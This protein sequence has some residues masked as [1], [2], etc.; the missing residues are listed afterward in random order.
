MGV[1]VGG[2]AAIGARFDIA[3][4]GEDQPLRR[5]RDLGDCGLE[6]LA[7][8]RGRGPEAADLA[9]VLPSGGLDLARRRGVVLVAEGADASTHATSVPQDGGTFAEA[10]CNVRLIHA[11][12]P[13][14]I[15]ARLGSQPEGSARLDPITFALQLGFF[16]LFGVSVWQFIQHRG[17]LELS[18]MAIFGSIVAL[19]ALSLLNALL[20][21]LTPVARPVLIAILFAQPVLVLRLIAQIHP[22]RPLLFRIAF[23]GAIAAWAAVV[24]LPVAFPAARSLGIVIAV[25]YFCAVEI[26]AAAR[27]AVDSRRRYGVARL[28]LASASVATALFGVSILLAGLTNV[29]RAPGASSTDSTTVTRLLVLIA[30]IGYLG[31]FVPPGWFRRVIN[32]SASFHLV[33]TL[34]SP[35]TEMSPGALWTDLATTAREILGASRV[36]ILPASPGAP[37]A[38]VGDR[39]GDRVEAINALTT[40]DAATGTA[41]ALP[42]IST[43][44]LAVRPGREASERLVAEI[45]GRPL[46]VSDD[47]ALIADLASLTAQAI[48]REG[49]LIGLGEARREAEES[50]SIRS[51]EARFRALLEA[52]PN[53][54]LALDE[55]SNVTWATRQ[56]G[57][58]FGCDDH[59]LVGMALGDLVALHKDETATTGGEHPVF[60]SETTGRR[61]D[62]THFPAE[63]ARST[64]ELDGRPF[65]V[66]V[67]SDVTWRHEADQI[68]DRFVGVLSHELRTPV[69]SIYGGTQVLL[70]RGARLD[71][72][73]RNELLVNVA[74]EA[75][76]LQRMIENLVAMARIERGGDF[77]STRPVL[78]DRIIPQLVERERALWPEVTIEYVPSGPIQMVA[79][80][81]EYLAQIMRNLLSNAAKYSG[82]GSTVKVSLEDGDGEVIVRVRDD[83]PGV[84]DEDAERLFGLYYRSALQASTAPGAGIGL[85]VCREL[86]A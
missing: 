82:P 48:D 76:R 20:P 2:R 41:S 78:I 63:I 3:A 32:R 70:R 34:V 81:E 9:H 18:V 67:V 62:G 40:G 39:P 71:P 17:P 64:F 56:A 49:M 50:R 69:T 66:A 80:D 24:V 44:D 12:V 30:T 35:P 45:E 29:A 83:G 38:A 52:D 74:A 54:I 84:A 68:R 42:V 72:E 43:V 13:W 7:V 31:A 51:S 65:Q 19:F 22:F 15:M 14:V 79:A 75:E 77:G 21:A 53:A 25:V 1:G 27:F 46:F 37:L 57:E 11:D 58:L 61:I 85:F 4:N 33:R 60:R 26:G 36:S 28:R 10:S 5:G 23:V 73:T 8:A 16:V 6:G 86:V 47:L 55:D 59:Q